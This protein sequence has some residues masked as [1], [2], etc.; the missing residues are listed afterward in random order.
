MKKLI[1]LSQEEQKK[2]RERI[3]R[4]LCLGE[5]SETSIIPAPSDP[6][7]Q[8]SFLKK[9]MEDA[10]GAKMKGWMRGL[11]TTKNEADF[12]LD[13]KLKELRSRI[14][15]AKEPYAD[16]T[17]R[18]LGPGTAAAVY[19]MYRKTRSLASFFQRLFGDAESME[20]LMRSVLTLRVKNAK[21]S[22]LDYISFETMKE[23]FFQ[24]ESR[25]DVVEEINKRLQTYF[26]GLKDEDFDSLRP[27][28]LPLYH[29]KNLMFFP[30][31]QFFRLFHFELSEDSSEDEPAFETSELYPTLEHL[32]RFFCA[33]YPFRRGGEEMFPEILEFCVGLKG[34][35]KAFEELGLA[36]RESQLVYFKKD[37]KEISQT[38]L[39]LYQ[40]VPFAELIRYFKNDPFYKLMMYLPKPRLKDFFVHSL[41][42]KLLL[43]FE[44]FFSKVRL[45]IL[46]DM[47][48]ILFKGEKIVDFEFYLNTGVGLAT[49]T[50]NP[51]FIHQ[52]SL[53]ILNNFIRLHYRGF[54]QELV[55]V[56]NR[57][58]TNRLR[59]NFSMIL[60]H[61]SGIEEVGNK[62]R[63]YD[64]S[65]SP[66]ADD[67]R[68]LIKMKFVLDR[69]VQQMKMYRTL[70]AQKD[71][72][73]K[74]LLEKGISHLEGLLGGI[75]AM[76]KDQVFLTES[77]K[78]IRGLDTLVRRASEA[79]SV[80]VKVVRHLAAVERGSL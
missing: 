71:K 59:N 67:G 48:L 14:L 5:E 44:D 70:I 34:G 32:E 42:Y 33:L 52:R 65:F 8:E 6:K 9:E 75:E 66:D 11:F 64:L 18:T 2:I 30:Y 36:D 55:H 40:S 20:R 41:R 27:G 57:A 13:G 17:M 43:D 31:E 26:S 63:E 22:L 78:K 38:A 56:L 28:I 12:L 4:A 76:E 19:E 15:A 80:A 25:Q 60:I 47:I 3:E 61:A 21:T 58:V 23:L 46:E 16:F 53:V 29:Y 50:G 69:D 7:M 54:V 73:A 79:L 77:T 72:E 49:K 45:D 37:L 1:S 51:G 24:T 74:E 10:S 35:N 39:R 62:L 68:T